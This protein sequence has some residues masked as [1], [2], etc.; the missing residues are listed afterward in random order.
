MKNE[1][2]IQVPFM[3]KTLSYRFS[4]HRI[5]LT[6]FKNFD[7]TMAILNK[8]LDNE[9]NQEYLKVYFKT[10]K[11]ELTDTKIT[12]FTLVNTG[13]VVQENDKVWCK[14]LIAF[15]IL[16]SVSAMTRLHCNCI[17]LDGLGL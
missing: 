11:I 7:G 14:N 13:I 10:E 15:D 8:Y 16:R 12:F 1:K 2:V 4:D 17:V 5:C 3:L 9:N 6:D